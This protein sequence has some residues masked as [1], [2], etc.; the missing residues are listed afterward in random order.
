MKQWHI[1]EWTYQAV[2]N[3][4]VTTGLPFDLLSLVF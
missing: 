3:D 4:T 2:T 1:G